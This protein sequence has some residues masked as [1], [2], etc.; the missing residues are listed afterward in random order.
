MQYSISRLSEINNSGFSRIPVFENDRNN[1]VA[2]LHT[3]NL[4]FVDAHNNSPLKTLIEFY[5][6]PL[7]FVYEDVT[8]NVMLNEFK[9]GLA[10]Y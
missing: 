10:Q 7:Y 5:K 9:L 2:I 3:R 4:A 8:L 1:V 6:H